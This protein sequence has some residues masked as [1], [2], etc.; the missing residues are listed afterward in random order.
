[1][2]R[3]TRIFLVAMFCL[4]VF[5]TGCQSEEPVD[6]TPLPVVAAPPYICEYV[7]LRAVQLMT[8]IKDPL[9]DGGFDLS[10]YKGLGDGSCRVYRPDGDRPRVLQI[11]LTPVGQREL[12]EEYLSDGAYPLPEIVPGAVGAYYPS[13]SSRNNAAFAVL[14]RGR[15]EVSVELN[16]GVPGRD[17][18]ADAAALMKL[19]APKLITDAS[20]PKKRQ[21]GADGAGRDD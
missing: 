4:L 17:N 14:V 6:R 3:S 20:A 2:T 1:M 12:V 18:A 7:P 19:I 15:T 5:S 13:P 21:P 16:I 8:G 9:V 10:D 11:R